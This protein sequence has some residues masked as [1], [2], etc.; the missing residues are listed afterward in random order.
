VELRSNSPDIVAIAPEVNV[1]TRERPVSLKFWFFGQVSLGPIIDRLTS[2]QDIRLPFGIPNLKNFRKLT[3]G[4]TVTHRSG[5]FRHRR[6]HLRE[7]GDLPFRSVA[8]KRDLAL[9]RRGRARTPRFDDNAAVLGFLLF[10]FAINPSTHGNGKL[11]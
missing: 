4:K 2:D 1:A 3:N 7:V 9:A 11:F 8:D 10:D 6:Q 5:A